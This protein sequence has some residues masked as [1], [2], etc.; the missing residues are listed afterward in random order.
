VVRNRVRRRLR[1]LVAAAAADGAL[2]AGD[3]LISVRPAAAERSF[4]ELGHD[5]RAA[6][7]RLPV[8]AA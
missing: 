1:A 8:A 3:H 4:A 5:L 7:G 2:G 6:L